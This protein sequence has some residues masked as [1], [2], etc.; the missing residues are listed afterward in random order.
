MG[1]P[2]WIR[3][4]NNDDETYTNYQSMS[5]TNPSHEDPLT[6]PRNAAGERSAL[7]PSTAF[8]GFS[9]SI[10]DMFHSTEMERVDCCAL[11]C[12][13]FLQND[14]D[15]Y[16][17]TG[18]TPPSPFK[19][20]IMH[21]ILPSS[22]FFI[23]GMGAMRI[24]DA[25]VNQIFSTGL[26]ALLIFY[27]CM[28]CAKGRAKRVEIRKDL[29]FT[30]YQL[31]RGTNLADALEHERPEDEE[32]KEE[33]RDYYLGQS[34]RD[35]RAAHPCCLIGCYAD[36]RHNEPIS[37][38]DDNVCPCMYDIACPVM[39][40][41]YVQCCGLCAIAQ[42]ARDIERCVLPA[43]YRRIDYITMEPWS[44]FYPA[45]YRHKHCEDQPH[46]A[47]E[48]ETELK[49]GRTA[50]LL[51]HP[52]S[53]LSARLLQSLLIFWVITLVW[54]IFGPLILTRVVGQ[55]GKRHSFGVLD[56]VLLVLTFLQSFA[57]L[58]IWRYFINRNKN[59]ELSM[60]AL[61]KYFSSGFFLAASLALFWE[62]LAASVVRT[63]VSL[64][65]AVAGVDVMNDPESDSDSST[66]MFSRVPGSSYLTSI[67]R[68]DYQ[69]VFGY[70]HPVF[71]VIYL[72]IA[73]FLVAA[74]IEELCKY[75]SFR[76]VE[77][78]DFLSRTELDESLALHN[79]SPDHHDDEEDVETAA[80]SESQH[81][82]QV[83]Y[84]KQLESVETQ[85]AAITLAMV[86]VAIGFACCENIMYIFFYA[87]H[88]FQLE[89]GVLI[90][91]SF[92]PVHPILAAIQS[93]GVCKRDLESSRRT[94]L[95]HII[96]PAVLFHGTYDFIILVIEFVGKLVGERVEDGDLHISNM[97]ELLSVLLCMFVMLA[98]LLYF[99]LEAG[100][101]R[102]RLVAL[103]RQ[104]S[105]DRS[106]LI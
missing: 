4:R 71:Y 78:P 15:R 39:C 45:V 94:K 102:K 106:G 97:A 25:R 51:G 84:A 11:T 46:G 20:V 42:E 49:D 104:S 63:F 61:V 92:F 85:G 26:I 86:S 41:M 19:R 65:L 16:F 7:D 14:R 103:D 75:F 28:Q 52:L 54:G 27:F 8:R 91:R 6:A 83:D 24:R 10:N 9:T 2:K 47:E 38:E 17:L 31:Q 21:V 37:T 100:K 43:N 67:G 105:V 89:L 33:E 29:L 53:L 95:G 3:R 55:R 72:F 22:L 60:D 101:Q 87:G 5:E 80:E 74:F 82:S 68:P 32:E 40:G 70:D 98:S 93:L 62:L 64:L 13:G 36:D 50:S 34:T 59:S 81:A 76:M 99:C 12:C 18:V 79:R 23:A 77:H 66:V 69:Q 57:I 58:A 90:E 44:K 48:Q 35:F 56:S 30:K 1:E 73:T 96:L 88:S